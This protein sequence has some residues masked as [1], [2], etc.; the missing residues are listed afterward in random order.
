MKK[1]YLI[2]WK[3]YYEDEGFLFTRI[4]SKTESKVSKF[5]EEE[6]EDFCKNKNVEEIKILNE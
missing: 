4:Y 5:T 2:K 6:L 1:L 3:E